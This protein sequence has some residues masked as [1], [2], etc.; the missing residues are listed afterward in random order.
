MRFP[1]S[2]ALISLVF[3]ASTLFLIEHFD[4]WTSFLSHPFWS[5]KVNWIGM[6]IGAVISFALHAF[7]QGNKRRLIIITLAFA[8][9][10][11]GLYLFTSVSKE[12]FAASYAEDMLAGKFWYFGFMA[13]IASLFSL[14]SFAIT[15]VLSDKN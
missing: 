8:V 15:A 12:T 5:S 9:V 7:V 4:V 1:S 3:A 2:L 6:G 10:A 11:F 13:Y 14:F